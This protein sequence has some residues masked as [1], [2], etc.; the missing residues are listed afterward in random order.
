MIAM[1][2]AICHGSVPVALC[3]KRK[4]AAFDLGQAYL[5]GAISVAE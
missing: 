3:R 4:T 2:A 1:G 5:L